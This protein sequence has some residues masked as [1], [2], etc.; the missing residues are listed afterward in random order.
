MLKKDKIMV[1]KVDMFETARIAQGTYKAAFRGSHAVKAV[2][3]AKVNLYLEVG[4]VRPDG[5]H[6]VLTVMHT[7][8]LHDV[9]HIKVESAEDEQGLEIKL[10]CRAAEGLEELNIDTESNIVT[11]AIRLLAKLTGRSAHETVFVDLEKN[12][13]AQAG[14]GGGSSDAA[15]ALVSMA[16]LWGID[17]NDPCLEQAARQ[18]GSDVAFFLR[19]SCALFSGVGDVFER[20]LTHLGSFVVLVKAEGGV[21]TPSAY[22]AFD[23]DPQMIDPENRAKALGATSAQEVPLQNNLTAAS[24]VLLPELKEVESWLLKQAGITDVLMSGSGAV[25]FALCSSAKDASSVVAE[26]RAKGW[27]AR[28][29]LFAPTRA[30]VVP[31]R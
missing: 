18:L 10:L 15:A 7:L 19:G 5:Y 1:N 23:D 21:S 3:P 30:A 29:T 8:L 16:S 26:A 6:D 25:T 31:L 17:R 20:S 24:Q 14:L 22:R 4:N 12:I 13:P 28:S 2:A 11:R 9:M 27:W